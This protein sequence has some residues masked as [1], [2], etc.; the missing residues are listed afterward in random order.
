M[1]S[2][3]PFLGE[4]FCNS[5]I[6]DAS[7]AADEVIVMTSARYGR[8]K[9]G[10]CVKR[11]FGYL[12]CGNDALAAFDEQCSG[13]TRCSVMINNALWHDAA[14]ACPEVVTG[15][16]EIEYSCEKGMG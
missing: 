1:K 11:D 15:H 16:A 6:F 12:G 14:D 5:E 8:M 4:E 2:S 3:L 10:R 7:C 9:L 13:K